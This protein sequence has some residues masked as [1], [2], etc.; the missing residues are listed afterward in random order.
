M[1]EDKKKE[2][3]DS[4]YYVNKIQNQ[5]LSRRVLIH[6]NRLFLLAILSSI[7]L[8]I[9]AYF[10][11][12]VSN[13]KRVAITGNKYLDDAYYRDMSQIHNDDK[14]LLSFDSAIEKEFKECDLIEKVKVSHLNHNVV[15]IDITEKNVVGYIKKDVPYL[16][17]DDGTEVKLK[18]EYEDILLS[19]PLIEGYTSD[20]LKT[21]VKGFKKLNPSMLNEISEIHK[22]PFSYDE[23][24]LEIIMRDGYYVYASYFAL[25]LLNNYYLMVSGIDDDLGK[26]CIFLDETNNSAFT[27]DCPFWGIEKESEGTDKEDSEE[28]TETEDE[29]S[30]YE[31]ETSD[32]EE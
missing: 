19:V 27:S 7:I 20:E 26:P 11:L 31:D 15:Q 9:V 23:M 28:I 13:I 29:T 2:I 21:I 16:I 3:L 22:Y 4:N 18:K 8:I 5:K 25:P 30:D 14:Y 17:L 32:Y 24:T 6:K 10:A 1:L 12:P